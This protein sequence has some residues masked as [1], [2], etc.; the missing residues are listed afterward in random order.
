M[1]GRG[2]WIACRQGKHRELTTYDQC[3][4]RSG[5]EGL[6]DCLQARKTKAVDYVRSVRVWGWVGGAVGL[7][8]DKGNIGS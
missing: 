6:L 4:C 3:E 5:W 8:A 1:G 2:C 7:P